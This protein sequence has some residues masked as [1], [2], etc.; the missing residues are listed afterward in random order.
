MLLFSRLLQGA[1]L[2]AIVAGAV[3]LFGAGIGFVAAGV[4]ALLTGAVLERGA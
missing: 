2:A 1:G 3:V 4:A